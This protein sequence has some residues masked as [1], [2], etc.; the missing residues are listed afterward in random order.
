MGLL[1]HG[2]VA[3]REVLGTRGNVN[4][5]NQLGSGVGQRL[6]PVGGALIDCSRR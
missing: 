5:R 2:D 4:A 3:C 1:R 6:L